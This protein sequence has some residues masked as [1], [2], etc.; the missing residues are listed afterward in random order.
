MRCGRAARTLPRRGKGTYDLHREGDGEAMRRSPVLVALFATL[1][2]L[3]L[4]PRVASAAAGTTDPAANPNA[5]SA[6]VPLRR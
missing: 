5:T 1:A 4:V 3:L 2:I 6:K